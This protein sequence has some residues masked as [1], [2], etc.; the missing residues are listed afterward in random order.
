MR[1]LFILGF[2][3]LFL[4]SC[5]TTQRHVASKENFHKDKI[6]K[7]DVPIIQYFFSSTTSA[8]LRRV[9]LTSLTIEQ[10][11]VYKEI[12]DSTFTLKPGTPG[13][14][15]YVYRDNAGIDN[16]YVG[17]E[18]G[19]RPLPF[20]ANNRYKEFRLRVQGKIK[21]TSGRELPAVLLY[22]ADGNLKQAWVVVEANPDNRLTYQVGKKKKVTN[23]VAQGES[24]KNKN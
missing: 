19:F 12:V 9:H 4:F 6:K 2:S 22:D 7:E 18:E 14:L 16:F 11:T 8:V 10:G 17:F 24:I 20:A 15:K 1:F 5:A 13:L 23:I 21:T 3:V